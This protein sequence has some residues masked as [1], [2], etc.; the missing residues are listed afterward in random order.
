MTMPTPPAS[1]T[2]RLCRRAHCAAHAGDDLAAHLG[3]VQH[4]L[5]AV[6]TDAAA[7]LGQGG[8]G[9]GHAASSERMMVAGSA[10]MFSEA[11]L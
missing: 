3:R 7:Q 5:A 2:A 11:P 10:V 6:G 4:G 9:A 1:S 8:V